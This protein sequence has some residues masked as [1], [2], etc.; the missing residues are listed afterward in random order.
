[1]VSARALYRR[2]LVTGWELSRLPRDL[3][4][5]L[6]TA[7]A[8]E[9]PIDLDE[10]LRRVAVVVVTARRAAA[11]QLVERNRHTIDRVKQRLV[12]HG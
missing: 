5:R 8:L 12:D 4:D 3:E 2:G 1:M 6:R 9:S 10:H 7:L 11:E